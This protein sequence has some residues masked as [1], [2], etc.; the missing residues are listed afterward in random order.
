MEGPSTVKSEDV[1]E[2]IEKDSANKKGEIP[3]YFECEY[4]AFKE[5][6]DYFGLEPPFFKKY[7]LKEEAYVIEDPF[8]PTKQGD[9]IILG[10]RCIHCLKNVCKDVSCSFYFNGTYCITC[11][12]RNH[13]T[14]PLTV[15]QKLSKIIP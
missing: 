1:V 4:C 11:A 12:K 13:E 3:R 9:I 2:L 5:K 8:I 14:F 6:Y 15:Q 7:E 10:A